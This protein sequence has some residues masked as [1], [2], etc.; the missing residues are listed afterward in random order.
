[1]L[2][3]S[4]LLNMPNRRGWPSCPRLSHL[5]AACVLVM[6]ATA[7]P[8][9]APSLE[10]LLARYDQGDF[11]AVVRALAAL[12]S[13]PSATP[14]RAEEIPVDSL[15]VEWLTVAPRWIAAGGAEATGRRQ[16]VA[17]SFALELA[18]ARTDSAWYL[19]YPFVA[20][21]CDL[22]RSSPSR[23]SGHRW[24]Y[25]ASIGVMQEADDWAHVAGGQWTQIRALHFRRRTPK[26]F[27]GRADQEEAIDGHLS[28]AKASFPEEP[29]WLLVAAQF[30]E[31]RT[32]LEEAM[33]TGIS[34]HQT[35]PAEL[36]AM[37]AALKGE[38]VDRSNR[39][40]NLLFAKSALHRA[41]LVQSVAARY[42]ALGVQAPLRGDAALH[43]GFLRIRF[44]DWDAA[45]RYLA[46]VPTLTTEPV[47]VAM[48]HHF[49]GWVYQQTN[50]RAEAI[51][52]YRRA[53]ALA[54][55][56]RSTSILLA[57][58][59]AASGEVADAYQTLHEAHEARPAPAIFPPA[60]SSA[61]P[62]LD[63]WPMYPRGD[64]AL[65]PA[66]LT[67]LREALR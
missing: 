20:W 24:W 26:Q 51:A 43:L 36:E 58:Q 54:P 38:R 5:L 28:H 33:A 62:P 40:P 9:A 37:A 57:A 16:L 4:S 39:S 64:A 67:R 3:S 53:L 65:V 14:K 48:S 66:Y 49:A 50:R 35:S 27:L 61:Q 56:S 19:R 29:R 41:G 45:L 63:L 8:A 17:A 15:F 22:L 44:E 10:E 42:E 30:E 12:P 6:S 52:A 2:E 46:D 59:L 21:A 55:R 23:T 25:L 18:R 7:A 47:A 34:G 1:M 11:E 60:P 13:G 31:S 32:F